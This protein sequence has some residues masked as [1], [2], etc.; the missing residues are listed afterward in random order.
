MSKDVDELVD[1]RWYDN[2]PFQCEVRDF[3]VPGFELKMECPSCGWIE[4][5]EK[6]LCK[7]NY[8][9]YPVFNGTNVIEYSCR[10]HKTVSF[11]YRIKLDF[12]LESLEAVGEVNE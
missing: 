1:C 9:P 5:V 10:C 11:K 3:D 6:I 8:I 2:I 4:D 12:Q 7:A